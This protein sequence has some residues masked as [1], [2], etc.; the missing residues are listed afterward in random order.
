MGLGSINSNA[1][2]SVIPTNLDKPRTSNASIS[3]TDEMNETLYAKRDP[4]EEFFMLSVLA[5]KL[6]HT[7]IYEDT[8]HIYKQTPEELFQQ[9][10]KKNLSFHKWFKW[11]EEIFETERKKVQKEK[12]ALEIVI[13]EQADEE[14]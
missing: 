13:E 8:E 9:V 6:N 3:Q 2:K 1:R 4:E 10:K 12:Q 5:I 7:E 14:P 11:L